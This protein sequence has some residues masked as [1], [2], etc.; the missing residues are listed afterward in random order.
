MKRAAPV[1]L[2]RRAYRQRR[3]RDGARMLPL[4]GAFFLVLPILW[5]P[6]TT[7]SSDTAWDGIYL[8]AVWLG[9]IGIAAILSH[10][11]GTGDEG[12]TSAADDTTGP[13][14]P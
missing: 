9:L 12:D 2:A 10:G 14:A 5:A 11:L 13:G 8:F 1:F 4:A 7:A 3:L 6:A